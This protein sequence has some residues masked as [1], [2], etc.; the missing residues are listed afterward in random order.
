MRI[1]DHHDPECWRDAKW[2]V[3]NF[4]A[5]RIKPK[6]AFTIYVNDLGEVI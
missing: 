3:E 4:A 1:S 2:F 6:R 5:A